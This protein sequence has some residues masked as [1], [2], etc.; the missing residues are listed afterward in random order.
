MIERIIELSI[1]RR[2]VVITSGLALALWGLYAAYH[3]PIDA[4]PDLS[5]NQ[6][7]VYADWP[8]H[9]PREIDDQVTY[10]LSVALQGIRGV[11]VV[12]ASSDVDYAWL[13]VI[14]ED[15]V[16]FPQARRALAERLA[17][18][19]TN[20]P[21]GVVP[22]VAP[23]AVATGQIFWY[24]IEGGGLDLGRLRAIQDFFVRD[25]LAAVPGVAEVASVGGAP[26][27][28]QVN[29]DPL[30]LRAQGVTLDAVIAAVEAS[31][32]SAGGGVVHKS[33]AEF[34]VRSVGW[35]GNSASGEGRF[36]PTAVLRDLEAVP[37]LKPGGGVVPLAKVASV[38]LGSRP[39]RGVLEKDGNEVAGGVVLMAHGENPRD[40]TERI[41]NKVREIQ[42]GLPT[43]V[44]IIPF[45]DRTPLIDG[46]IGTVTGTL[47][48]AIVTATICVV[49]ILL[50]LRTSFVIA[51]TLPLAILASFALMWLLRWLG[52]ADVQ[53]NIMSLAGIVISIGVLVDSSVVM[54]ENAMHRLREHHGDRPVRGDTREIVLTA[55]QSVGRP[56]F[57]SVV[58]MLL[59]FLPVF[60]LGGMEGRMFRPLAA[61][62]CFALIAVAVLSITIVPALCTLFIR[63]RLRGEMDSPIVRG[64]VEIYRPVLRYLLD[65]PSPLVW[66]LA[67]T[68]VVGFT[69]IG[70]DSLFLGTLGAGLLA[71][72]LAPRSWGGRALAM[73]SLLLVAL[74]AKQNIEPLGR[75]FMTPLDEG[76]I[77]DMPITVPRASVTES[78]DDLKARNMIL[79]RFPEVDMVVGKAG[80]A[81]SPSDPAPLDMIETMVNFRRHEFW[82][83]RVLLER[84]ARRQT[85]AVLDALITRGL[86][87]PPSD[88]KARHALIDAATAA[89]HTQFDALMREYAYQRNREFERSLGIDPARLAL[90]GPDDAYLQGWARHVQQLDGELLHRGALTYTR[91]AIEE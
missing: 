91:L 17:G 88:Q 60:A 5:E 65:N 23:D 66:V 34:V 13:A 10:P 80:R 2:L 42:A 1:R 43:G 11:R 22:R 78:L 84:D 4:I 48:E 82:P 89:A 40:V 64:V 52:L 35:L 29:I 50:H 63:G 75:E 32:A 39:R 49:L 87:L 61:T 15:S 38:A 54:A 24:T 44:R 27:E 20:L 41:K 71:V 7:I 74:V 18:L 31:N 16:D 21:T 73:G 90:D 46:A 30:Q 33:N 83:R 81:E 77:M 26:I 53:T 3:T 58:I 25:Q 19:A 55:C 72:G 79:C 76:M 59:S 57:F 51:A 86:I 14:F 28:Y 47:V 36:D 68:F 67:V 69:P 62:K 70:N 37:I 85:E 8:G 6:V 9:S 45:Y 56:I 12:R